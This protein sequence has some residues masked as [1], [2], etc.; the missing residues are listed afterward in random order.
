M[1]PKALPNITE[2]D[3]HDLVTYKVMQGKTI[4]CKVGLPGNADQDKIRYLRAVSS[5]ANTAGGDLIYGIDAPS[6]VPASIPGR[7]GI[8]EDQA[9]LRWKT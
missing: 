9:R 2:T 5:F 7:S 1:V 3:L 6:G 4:E 8:D